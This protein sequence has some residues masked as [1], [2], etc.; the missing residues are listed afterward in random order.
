MEGE[1]ERFRGALSH[2]QSQLEEQRREFKHARSG[3]TRTSRRSRALSVHVVVFRQAGDR[4]ATSVNIVQGRTE[5]I[6]R[7]IGSNEQSLKSAT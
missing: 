7:R 5:S 1:L 3:L 6:E 4:R 2:A